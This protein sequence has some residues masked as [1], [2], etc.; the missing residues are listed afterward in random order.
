MKLGAAP[1][2]VAA[3]TSQPVA[4][5]FDRSVSNVH[6]KKSLVG[7]DNGGRTLPA[8]ML[9]K[10]LAYNGITF[11][12][13]PATE[14]TPNSVT[15][16][17]QTVNLPSGQFN[18]VYVLA[19]AADGDQKATFTIGDKAVP[20]TIQDWG[21][22]L[23]QWDNRMWSA[24]GERNGQYARLAAGFIKRTPVAWFAS[25]R[26]SADGSPEFYSYSYL[27][28]YA[29]D[30]PAGAKTLTL[31]SNNHIRLMA[32]TVAQ[33]SGNVAPA[34][35]LYDTLERS[36]PPAQAASKAATAPLAPMAGP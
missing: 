11:K 25:H 15:P 2:K 12:L 10:E 8:E 16:Q 30:L 22:F 3:I 34:Q 31:P 24:G 9:P 21:G 7:F 13:G 19:A 5:T 17:G 33:E 1:A 28:A 20:L 29:I 26:N 14:G 36:E 35:P 23:G 27:Y 6:G 18:R 4:L 32:V